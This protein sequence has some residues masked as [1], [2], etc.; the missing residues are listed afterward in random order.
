MAQTGETPVLDL[1][2]RMTEDSLEASSPLDARTVMLVRLAALIAVDAPPASYAI[3]VATAADVGVSA[4][5]MRGLA[6]AIAPIVG[7]PRVVAAVGN[8]MRGLAIE[9]AALD[10]MD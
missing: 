10:D 9:L 3:N 5:E 4:E 1:I 2:E 7:T 6:A 8:I